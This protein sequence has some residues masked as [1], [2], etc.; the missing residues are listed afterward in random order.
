MSGTSRIRPAARERQ[1]EQEPGVAWN[2]PGFRCSE[3]HAPRAATTTGMPRDGARVTLRRA[4]LCPSG[5]S[6]RYDAPASGVL[7]LVQEF[8]GGTN[9]L[10]QEAPEVNN[11]LGRY[12]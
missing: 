12:T 5:S 2:V 4:R 7:V 11:V 10:L 9:S 6:L 8:V 1:G 3:P